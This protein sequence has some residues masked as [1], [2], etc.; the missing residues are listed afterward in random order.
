[1]DKNVEWYQQNRVE[2]TIQNLQKNN[3]EGYFVQD[4]KELIEK[5]EELVKDGD[6]VSVGGS[7][8]LFEAG[9]MEHLRSSRYNFLDRYKEGLTKDDIKNIYR[10]SFCTDTYFM[11]TNALT[12][13][14]EL[15]NID[16]NGN[17][18]AALIYGPDQVI[19]VAGINKIVADLEEAESRVKNCAAPIN[20]K[21]LN[22]NT[23]CTKV[24]YCVDCH[25]DDRICS[26][27]VVTR[28]Q[29][30]GNKGRIKVIIVNKELGY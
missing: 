24:G 15:F 13:N 25:S 8:T 1:M 9:V 19:I 22:K 21:R 11:S 16:G 14:G 20:A 28:R 2:K 27:Y 7:M 29:N 5:I 3:M 18:V 26:H 30:L 6:T 17:R 23:P 4:E 10:K 12:E